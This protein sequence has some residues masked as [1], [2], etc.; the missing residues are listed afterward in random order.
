M[1]VSKERQFL[2]YWYEDTTDVTKPFWFGLYSKQSNQ[3]IIFAI[4]DDL[5]PVNNLLSFIS[6]PPFCEVYRPGESDMRS[7]KIAEDF[8]LIGDGALHWFVGN[9]SELSRRHRVKPINSF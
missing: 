4:M 8:Q 2:A 3:K 9:I 7:V 5:A 6:G 1:P